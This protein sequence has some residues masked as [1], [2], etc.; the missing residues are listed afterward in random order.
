MAADLESLLLEA[1]DA[2]VQRR[3][4]VTGAALATELKKRAAAASINLPETLKGERTTFLQFVRNSKVVE[5]I[6][7]PQ[8]DFLVHRKGDVSVDTIESRDAV[9]L[10]PDIYDAFTKLRR[11]AIYYNRDLDR[12]EPQNNGGPAVS[13][14]SITDAIKPREIYAQQQDPAIRDEWL[15]LLGQSQPLRRFA[16]AVQERKLTEA[17]R[18]YFSRY[19]SDRMKAW[20]TASKVVVP[21]TWYFSKARLVTLDPRSMLR[22]LTDV[23]SDDEIRTLSIPLRAVE[24]FW[25]SKRRT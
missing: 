25:S 16:K 4:P 2:C 8:R 21:V 23:M 14:I 10:R 12:F 6:E 18:T 11:E 22:E 1:Y 24:A 3:S 17:W 13:P 5:P 15:A 7:R 9:S 19:T 20:A